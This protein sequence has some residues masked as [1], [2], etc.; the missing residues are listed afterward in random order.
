[1]NTMDLVNY[2]KRAYDVLNI[3]P[4]GDNISKFFD[5]ALVILIILNVIAVM[6]ETLP[7]LKGQY[8]QAFL[9]FDYFS[10]VVFAIEYSVR[11]WSCVEDDRLLKKISHKKMRLKYILSPMALIDLIA[12][13]PSLLQ[14]FFD[15][16]LRFLRVLRLL[17]MFKLTRYSSSMEMV[18]NVF[19]KEKSA[20]I[21]AFFVLIVLMIIA[22]GVMYHAENE[23]QPEAFAS[24]PHALWW[25]VVTLTTVGYGDVTPVTMIGKIFGGLIIIGSVG[26]VALPAGIMASAFAE[27]MRI[28]KRTF[29]YSIEKALEDGIIDQDEMEKLSDHALRL[30]LDKQDMEELIQL[31][32]KAKTMLKTQCPHCGEAL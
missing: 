12:F 31:S 10:A 29:S 21:S 14:M 22:A 20:F 11:V 32:I 13:L 2:R 8:T 3:A 23:L 15:S 18:L 7:E 26:I 19:R 24:I 4:D 9:A 6:L 30:G 28:R 17:R 27:E 1:M 16:D 5:I 25:A